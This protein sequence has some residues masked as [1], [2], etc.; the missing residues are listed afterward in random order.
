MPIECNQWPMTE[1]TLPSGEKDRKLQIH[2]KAAVERKGLK[3]DSEGKLRIADPKAIK[4]KIPRQVP[5]VMIF[6]EMKEAGHRHFLARDENGEYSCFGRRLNVEKT[7]TDIYPKLKGWQH[8]ELPTRTVVDFELV[9]PGHPDSEVV[10]A[11]KECPE[12][13]EMRAFSIPIYKG[14][15]LIGT[16]SLNYIDGRKLLMRVLKYKKYITKRYTPIKLTRDN[17]I[18]V[19]EALLNK[20][21]ELDIE[22][23]VLKEMSTLGWYKLKGINEADVFV[24]GFKIS[25]AETRKGMVTAVRVAVMDGLDEK[26]VGNVSGFNIGEMNEMTEAYNKFGDKSEGYDANPFMY[27]TLRIVYQEQAGQ[28]G[29]KHAFR[30]CWRDDKAAESCT[31]DQFS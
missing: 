9:W 10:T 13:L 12:E 29:L 20:A 19:L 27:K 11:I 6:P 28:G 16:N 24:I 7:Y 3:R 23:F 4:I 31:M 30:D 26:Y 5:A 1:L 17:Q 18:Q 15:N 25:N 22:G 2:P 21:E 8:P 14:R